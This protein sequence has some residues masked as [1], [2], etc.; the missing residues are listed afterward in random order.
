VPAPSSYCIRRVKRL[1]MAAKNKRYSD[2]HAH[3]EAYRHVHSRDFVRAYRNTT[4]QTE[5]RR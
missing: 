3:M 4:F 5:V 2:L 1:A